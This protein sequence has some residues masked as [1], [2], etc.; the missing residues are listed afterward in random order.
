LALVNL[1]VSGPLRVAAVGLGTGTIAAYGQQGDYYCFYEINPEVEAI[2]RQFFT[3][4]TDCPAT[5]EV[6]LGDARLS[7]EQEALSQDYDVIALDAFSGDA[8]P[9]HLLT[10][11]AFAVYLR[12]L[13]PTGV[14]AVHT[15]NRHLDLQ[16][17]VALIARCYRMQAVGVNVVD[18]EGVGDSA[19]EW[20]LLTRNQEFLQTPAVVDGS[21][22]LDPPD[23][24]IHVWTDQYSNL[25]QIL[26]AREKWR[27][28]WATWR[29]KWGIA[30]S[31]G[32]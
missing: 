23:P 4:L 31:P 32:D 9:A 14:I 17:I 10:V 18:A 26:T 27:N 19:S 30:Q 22:P 28:T 5:V 21:W 12:H 29:Q 1:A 15:S 24:A 16:P 11:E 2:A 3:Y 8:I 6:K 20:L 13:K 7:M 25:F